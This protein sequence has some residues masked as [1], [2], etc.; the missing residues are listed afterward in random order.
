MMWRGADFLAGGQIFL[1]G[2]GGRFSLKGTLE[3][4]TNKIIKF[5]VKNDCSK[6]TTILYKKR[7]FLAFKTCFD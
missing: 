4:N 7:L 3:H 5:R 1:E 6:M 2:G